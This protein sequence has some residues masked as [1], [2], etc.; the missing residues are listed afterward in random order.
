MSRATA[1]ERALKAAG[2]LDEESDGL[3]GLGEKRA[4][5]SGDCAVYYPWPQPHARNRGVEPGT[6]A[7]I[8]LHPAMNV[9][10]VVPNEGELFEGK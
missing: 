10:L 3:V 4:I 6:R 7:K 9:L 2:A 8:Y 1:R 5:P